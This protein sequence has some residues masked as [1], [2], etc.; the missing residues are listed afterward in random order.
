MLFS[1]IN[2]PKFPKETED[3]LFIPQFLE[4]YKILIPQFPIPQGI[5][6]GGELESL[7]TTYLQFCDTIC[8]KC[9]RVEVEKP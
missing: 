7:C 8:T 5:K 3:C 2:S 9:V 4:E 6:Y 1:S